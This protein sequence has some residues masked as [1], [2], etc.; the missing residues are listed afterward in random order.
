MSFIDSYNKK[1]IISILMNVCMGP[2][3]KGWIE[4]G[5]FLK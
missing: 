5:Y 1:Q 3:T 2:M 4:L